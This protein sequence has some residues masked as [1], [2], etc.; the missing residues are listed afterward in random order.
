[1]EKELRIPLSEYEALVSENKKLK[2]FK[3]TDIIY[4]K[5]GSYLSGYSSE[6]YLVTKDDFI[7]KIL[8]EMEMLAI[9]N[10]DEVNRLR[11]RNGELEDIIKSERL[12]KKRRWYNFYII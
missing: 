7:T 6:Y 8:H 9:S 3:K 12:R 4:K 5:N 10:N 1:M 11:D 2:S